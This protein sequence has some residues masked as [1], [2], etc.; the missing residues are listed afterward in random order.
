MADFSQIRS[1][2]IEHSQR[3]SISPGFYESMLDYQC[4]RFGGTHPQNLDIV[5]K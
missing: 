3:V 4:V 2:I 1:C 5:L